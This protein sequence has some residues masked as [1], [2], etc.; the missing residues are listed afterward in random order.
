MS[1]SIPDL[2][3]DNPLYRK[4]STDVGCTYF[5][6]YR[7]VF[8]QPFSPIPDNISSLLPK[9]TI[10]VNVSPQ[11]LPTLTV[12]AEEIVM[13]T[14]SQYRFP[15]VHLVIHCRSISFIDYNPGPVVIDMSGEDNTTQRS[16][17][18]G[19]GVANDAKYTVHEKSFLGDPWPYNPSLLK[20]QTLAAKGGNASH[21]SIGQ[22]GSSSGSFTLTCDFLCEDVSKYSLQILTHGGAGSSG[23]SGGNGAAG[24]N[25]VEMQSIEECLRNDIISVRQ[26]VFFWL[27]PMY[28]P[29]T[30]GNGG[31]AGPGG[32]GG[33]GGD[34]NITFTING[35]QAT[36]DEKSKLLLI[37]ASAGPNGKDG[38]P[39]SAGDAGKKPKYPLK[40]TI[41]ESE[42]SKLA[43]L[44]SYVVK[45]ERSEY[46][47]FPGPKMY[48]TDCTAGNVVITS[49]VSASSIAN[50]CIPDFRYMTM[51]VDRLVFEHFV[52]FTMQ[53]YTS[54]DSQ[55]LIST[56]SIAELVMPFIQSKTWVDSIM[57][58][59]NDISSST[60]PSVPPPTYSVSQTLHLKLLQSNYSA[61]QDSIHR[62]TD[63][64]H[65]SLDQVGQAG[66]GVKQMDDANANYI[67]LEQNLAKVG[68]QLIER[69]GKSTEIRSQV[70]N[71]LQAASVS[72]NNRNQIIDNLTTLKS[73]IIAADSLVRTRRLQVERALV[74]AEDKIRNKAQC[75]V[76]DIL[77]AISM[78]AMF[79]NPESAVVF[80]IGAMVEVGVGIGKSVNASF[81]TLD[82]ET[83]GSVDKSYLY[84]RITTI[85]KEIDP[86]ETLREEFKRAEG[87]RKKHATDYL[88]QVKAQA[89]KFESLCEQYYQIEGVAEG[90]A[91][92]K[93][94]IEAVQVKNDLLDDYNSNFLKIVS[95]QVEADKAKEVA[96][97]LQVVGSLDEL[98]TDELQVAYAFLEQALSDMK[99]LMIYKLYN[100]VR[101]YNAITLRHSEMV[102]PLASLQSFHGINAT[103][104]STIF[105]TSFKE[106]DLPW[107]RTAFNKHQSA[108][109]RVY[110]DLT[111][112]DFSPMFQ[113]LREKGHF[114]YTLEHEAACSLTLGPR[115]FMKEWFDVRYASVG[116]YFIGAVKLDH[117][118]SDPVA[119]INTTVMSLGASKVL[120]A[121]GVCHKFY[122]PSS[123]V[124]FSYSYNNQA[125][126]DQLGIADLKPHSSVVVNDTFR[127]ELEEDHKHDVYVQTPLTTW[128]VDL[129][130]VYSKE[131]LE[132]DP[133][134][135][136]MVDLTNCHTI[137]LWFDIVYRSRGGD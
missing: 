137:Q 62:G 91:A 29:A 58:K 99:K 6:A 116:V 41:W 73:Q 121:K 90:K 31:N 81:N 43:D 82:T 9:K 112:K 87:E 108:K 123:S 92:F 125:S 74:H 25:G 45:E 32:Y 26:D 18:S 72:I 10:Q 70:I 16:D 7:S 136:T 36:D 83:G 24:G 40:T 64:F 115:R 104:I 5:L 128:H 61:L 15:G 103:M 94:F 80:A 66:L 37:D 96:T 79:L 65:N 21:G 76:T 127:F 119:V 46:V 14:G 30:G 67:L 75:N 49:G 132:K 17:G 135:K 35:K 12:F 134:L 55:S 68:Q 97:R 52:H 129:D 22:P 69:Q 23:G 13:L 56:K 114:T 88:T 11:G 27:L 130:E 93:Q 89:S 48:F 53:K 60:D 98:Q 4:E 20:D 85:G 118:V 120:D 100:M 122:F 102:A 124:P 19:P 42:K 77:S 111:E 126:K 109:T 50:V 101:M 110:L 133:K 63:I 33:N 131:E 34:V 106:Q 38:V 39:G 95:L 105:N 8:L 54:D 1:G 59:L 78:V 86:T 51:L 28:P 71:S 117:P 113:Q 84:G 3:L 44:P 57:E 2:N 107:L 47:T